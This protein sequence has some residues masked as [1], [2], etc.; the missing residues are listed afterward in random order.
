[1]RLHGAAIGHRKLH[2]I[3]QVVLLLGVLVVQAGQPTTQQTRGHSHDAAVNFLNL[4]LLGCGVFFFDDGLHHALGIAHQAAIAC[5][6]VGVQTQQ[7]Q[8]L[9]IANTEQG[10][11]G[12][13]LNQRHIT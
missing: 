6:V 9:A 13:G 7:G 8:M 12:V 10:L 11:Q 1:M 4:A 3:G 2:H 5:G